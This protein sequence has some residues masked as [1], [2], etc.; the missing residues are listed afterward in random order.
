MVW[1]VVHKH[2]QA[3]FFGS[4]KNINQKNIFLGEIGSGASIFWLITKTSLTKSSK[5]ETIHLKKYHSNDK[6]I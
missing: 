3:I 1:Y 6:M 5:H 4:I 2:T